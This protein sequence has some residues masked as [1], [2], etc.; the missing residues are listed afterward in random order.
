MDSALVQTERDVRIPV[1]DGK[2]LAADLYLPRGSGPWPAI[3]VQSPYGKERL[4]AALPHP[5]AH[6]WLDFWD[7][8]RFALVVSDWRGYHGSA[9]A[10]RG[11]TPRHRG[12]DGFDLVEWIASRTWCDGRVAAWGPSALGRALFRTAVEKPPHLVCGIPVV[13]HM[14]HFYEDFYEGGVLELAHVRAIESLGFDLV[15]EVR[16]EP[17][18]DSPFYRQLAQESRPG[19]LNVPLLF[20]TGWY[21]LGL[22]QQIRFFEET[23]RRGGTRARAW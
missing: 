15:P 17:I 6:S 13:S 20:V 5:S 3:L 16:G 4:G 14:G 2:W 9:A 11:E 1:R 12:R 21:D 18:S 7:R 23:R 8:E 19:L 10:G 22:R